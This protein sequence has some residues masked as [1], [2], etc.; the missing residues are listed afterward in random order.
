MTSSAPWASGETF[1][2]EVNVICDVTWK[3]LMEHKRQLESQAKR[4]YNQLRT[5]IVVATTTKIIRREKK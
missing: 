2:C 4:N 3:V 5:N 1:W